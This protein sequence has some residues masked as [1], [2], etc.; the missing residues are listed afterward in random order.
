V[1]HINKSLVLRL[2]YRETSTSDHPD[3]LTSYFIYFTSS[4][5]TD[6]I[7]N[8]WNRVA[9]RQTNRPIYYEREFLE[10]GGAFL[11][12]GRLVGEVGLKDGC[13][14]ERIDRGSMS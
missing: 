4:D 12:W 7:G 10:L 3:K 6:D 13:E 2:K 9:G 14:I 11:P 1:G 5:T 8:A